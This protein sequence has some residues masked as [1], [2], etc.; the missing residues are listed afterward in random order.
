[1]SYD[2]YFRHRS[3]TDALTP[4]QFAAYFH[5]RPYYTVSETQAWYEHPATGVYF[6]FSYD[7]IEGDADESLPGAEDRTSVS[8]N[9]NYYRPHTFGLEAEPE[10]RRLS[11]TSIFRSPI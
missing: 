4:S 9:L 1:M 7:V 11:S 5:G 3:G 10:V 8:F 2:L 6:S